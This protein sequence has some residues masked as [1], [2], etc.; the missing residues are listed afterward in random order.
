MNNNRKLNWTE[1]NT[2][3]VDE[4]TG[5]EFKLDLTKEINE[6]GIEES[7]DTRRGLASGIPDKPNKEEEIRKDDAE[8]SEDKE[9]TE[10]RSRTSR[11]AEVNDDDDEDDAPRKGRA[12]KRIQNLLADKRQASLEIQKRDYVIAQLMREKKEAERSS[13]TAQKEAWQQAINDK[14][15]AL[16]E[17][18]NRSDGKEVARLAQEVADATMRYN[19]F[20]A[21]EEEY[22]EEDDAPSTFQPPQT[23]PEVPEAAKSWISRNPWFRT[24]EKRQV[25]ARLISRDLTQEGELS[26]DSEEYWEELDSRMANFGVKKEESKPEQKETRTSQRSKGSPI[27]SRTSDEDS[28]YTPAVDRQ[29]VRKGNTVS[30]TPTAS[31][32]DMAERLNVPIKDYMKEKFKYAEQGY[33]GYV[34]IDI[35]GQ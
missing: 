19:A 24:D 31:D 28:G 23:Q 33:K 35:P 9:E 4:D 17:A 10:V 20:N 3:E 16:E 6:N 25:L 18:V 26:P 12:H 21:V 2:S 30:A 11:Q 13:A 32:Y 27:G 14:K 34:T 22:E 5:E 8:G 7:K 1:I 29:F 15:A